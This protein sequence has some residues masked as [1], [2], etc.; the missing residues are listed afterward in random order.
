MTGAYW[1]AN[2]VPANTIYK[3]EP[4]HYD[5]IMRAAQFCERIQ[6]IEA[7]PSVPLAGTLLLC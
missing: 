1:Q 2:I 4:R 5:A 3:V 7:R 6:L